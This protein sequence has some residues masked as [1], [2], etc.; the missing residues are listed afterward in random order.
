MLGR[1]G[2]DFLKRFISVIVPFIVAN[3]CYIVFNCISGARY[4]LH[5]LYLFVTGLKQIIPVGWFIYCLMIL[6][7]SMYI[8]VRWN[9]NKYV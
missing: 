6:Y 3:I 1:P 5:D 8:A 9:L 7:L 2:G 4:D